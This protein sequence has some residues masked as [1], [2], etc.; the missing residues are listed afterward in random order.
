M[1]IAHPFKY[2]PGT[3]IPNY[4]TITPFTY[5]DNY[6][7]LLKLEGLAHYVKN[8][9]VPE[10]DER[11]GVI[12]DTFNESMENLEAA[13][14]LVEQVASDAQATAEQAQ[15]ILENAN[16]VKEAIE[17]IETSINTIRGEITVI[18]ENAGS[19]LD[20]K[21]GVAVD[22]FNALIADVNT[23]KLEIEAQLNGLSDRLEAEIPEIMHGEFGDE[24]KTPWA[25]AGGNSTVLSVPTH[26]GSWESTH[27]SALYFADGYNGYKYWVA[28]TPYPNSNEAH[29]DPNISV[30]NDGINWSN[31]PG[32]TNPLDDQPG[33]PG[34]HNSD[35]NLVIG[36]NGRMYVLW[37]MVDRPNGNKNRLFWRSSNDGVNW[38]P[39]HEI[40]NLATGLLSPSLVWTGTRWEMYGVEG[41][42]LV[43]YTT[44]AE[45]PNTS[46]TWDKATASTQTPVGMVRLWHAEVKLQ[47][48]IYTGAFMFYDSRGSARGGDLFMATSANGL[49]W[50][51]SEI[52]I[53]PAKIANESRYAGSLVHIEGEGL[54]AKYELI[55]GRIVWSGTTSN[56]RLARAHVSAPDT[57]GGISLRAGGRQPLSGFVIEDGN[58]ATNVAMDITPGNVAGSVAVTFPEGRFDSAPLCF[59][60]RQGATN[61]NWRA[62]VS[63]ITANGCRVGIR[64]IHDEPVAGTVQVRFNVALF[65][66]REG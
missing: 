12:S 33:T 11:I 22:G 60:D 47:N 32:L 26:D 7:Y 51:V 8:T 25:Y 48:G 59:V 24:I 34:P 19:D 36:P 21:I 13:V 46:T 44:T 45:T 35:T 5:R 53:L 56:W 57:L 42:K 52:P 17:L 40:I 38:S 3:R 18:V 23:M 50:Q 31:P 29:E 55:Y 6:T 62:N 27:P 65:A 66:R 49:S 16:G 63:E 41:T 61:D 58:Y 43:R 10:I 64:N 30:S 14:D 37:R 1:T 9:L 28:H 15:L 4:T 2:I 54:A 20:D 39:K